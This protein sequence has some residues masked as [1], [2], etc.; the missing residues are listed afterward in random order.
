MVTH[1]SASRI[2]C[3]VTLLMSSK[4]VVPC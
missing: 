4:P 1:P 3:R 2:Q